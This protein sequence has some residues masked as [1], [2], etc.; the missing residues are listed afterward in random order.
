VLC[1]TLHRSAS[2]RQHLLYGEQ[3]AA[4]LRANAPRLLQSACAGCSSCCVLACVESDV[5][6]AAVYG[7]FEAAGLLGPARHQLPPHRPVHCCSQKTSHSAQVHQLGS[8]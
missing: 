5:G 7:A 3:D 8:T 6:R 4:S 1:L 2:M